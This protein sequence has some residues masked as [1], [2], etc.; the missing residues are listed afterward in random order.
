MYVLGSVTDVPLGAGAAEEQDAL[1]PGCCWSWLRLAHVIISSKSAALQS[2]MLK[3]A[4]ND[5]VV[6][7]RAEENSD[8]VTFLFESPGAGPIFLRQCRFLGSFVVC[9]LCIGAAELAS[10]GLA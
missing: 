10:S 5:D 8:V 4:S 6:T 7:M 9:P 2:K 1:C 3:C